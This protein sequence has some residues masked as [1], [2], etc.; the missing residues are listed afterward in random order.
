MNW[1]TI[2]LITLSA[3][4]IAVGLAQD[5][6]NIEFEE[7]THQFGTIQKGDKAEHTFTFTNMSDEAVV[8]QN[9]K[10]SCGC[11]TPNWTRDEVAPGETGEIQVKYNT[12]RVG[13]FTK[14]V[15]VTYDKAQRPV[16]LYI[17]GTVQAPPSKT[18][19]IYQHK[20]GNLAFD[21]VR[22][23]VGV[24][25]SDKEKAMTFKVKNI[26]PKPIQLDQEISKEMMFEVSVDRPR[27]LPGEFTNIRV[28]AIGS[29]F[30]NAGTFMSNITLNTNDNLQPSKGLAIS[31]NINKV[32][33]VEELAKLPNIA[34]ETLE[35]DAG[36]VLEGEKVVF[37]FKFT[38]TGEEPL[39]L[40]SVKAS[41][42]CTATAPKD[43]IIAG[44]ATSEIVA[45]FDSR[46]RKGPQTKTIT[47]RSNDPDQATVI[48]RL[49]VEVEQDPFHVND[50]GPAS[51]NRR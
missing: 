29:K 39:E 37:G 4:W 51:G 14:T 20:I 47:V 10:A 43:D 28:N 25:D 42:G 49:K 30:I 18:D 6:V 21:K 3:C 1:K 24:L 40:Q 17:K 45:T 22:E 15:T 16:V 44:G 2:A 7:T 11:T 9:V 31:G 13:A 27:L 38:N 46:N 34:F 33:T 32:M 23:N 36:K 19:D 12:N 35:Y 5:P 8:L 50:F 41:C 48:L 26:G